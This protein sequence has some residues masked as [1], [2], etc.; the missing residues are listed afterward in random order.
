MTTNGGTLGDDKPYTLS[1]S[2][3]N[4]KDELSTPTDKML[5]NCRVDGKG[6]NV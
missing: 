6:P 1:A 2:S 4:D 3:A 5:R